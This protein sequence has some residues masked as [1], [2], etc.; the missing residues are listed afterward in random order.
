MQE[1]KS[2]FADVDTGKKRMPKE[3]SMEEASL[4]FMEQRNRIMKEINGDRK[5]KLQEERYILVLTEHGLS[6]LA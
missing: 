5:Q 3:I 1:M 4:K 2:Q 6:V